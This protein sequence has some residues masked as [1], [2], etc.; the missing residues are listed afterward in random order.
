MPVSRIS[1]SQSKAV[2]SM[3]SMRGK[4]IDPAYD[5]HVVG[6]ADNPAHSRAGSPAGAGAAIKHGEVSGAVAKQRERFLGQ[7]GKDQLSLFSFLNRL[8]RIG[9]NTFDQKMIFLN[10]HTGAEDAFA[11]DAGADDLAEPVV[12]ES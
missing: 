7:G 2:S 3:D 12:V 1:F 5:K 8:E 10:V 6:S 11:G 4:Q 9:I